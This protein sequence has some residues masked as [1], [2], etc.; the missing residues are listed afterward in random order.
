MINGN[1]APG[2]GNQVIIACPTAEP[3][4]LSGGEEGEAMTQNAWNVTTNE[5]AGSGTAG[6]P[7]QSG[8]VYGWEAE[9]PDQ[10]IGTTSV[11]AFCA[12]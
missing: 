9:V 11:W 7:E 6:T 4:L 5:I 8:D 12:S 1:L 10:A 3:Y 2:C